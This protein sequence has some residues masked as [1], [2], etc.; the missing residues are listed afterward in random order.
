MLN[1]LTNDVTEWRRKKFN[2]E[3]KTKLSFH[4]QVILPLVSMRSWNNTHF[5]AQQQQQQQQQQQRKSE[6]M[7]TSQL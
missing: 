1:L 6:R 2:M 7:T 5:A 3:F 4:W